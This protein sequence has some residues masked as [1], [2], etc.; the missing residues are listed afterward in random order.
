MSLPHV[1]PIGP[2]V[3]QHFSA[4][5]TLV[6]VLRKVGYAHMPPSVVAVAENFAALAAHGP[7]P[8]HGHQEALNYV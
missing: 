4:I 5:F 2:I 1:V 8:R 3:L 7:A 6:L